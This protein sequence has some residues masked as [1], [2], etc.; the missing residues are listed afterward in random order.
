MC[1]DVFQFGV[2]VQVS[3]VTTKKNDVARRGV[4]FVDGDAQQRVLIIAGRHMNTREK[5]N[6]KHVANTAATIVRTTGAATNRCSV[7]YQRA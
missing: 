3:E 4:D 5:S 6:A 2:A 1:V 7:G